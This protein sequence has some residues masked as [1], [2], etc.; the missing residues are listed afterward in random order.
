M[1]KLDDQ[2]KHTNRRKFRDREWEV[3]GNGDYKM[4]LMLMWRRRMRRGRGSGGGVERR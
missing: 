3:V 1:G 2:G 4:Q